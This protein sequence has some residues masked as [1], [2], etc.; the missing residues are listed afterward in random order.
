MSTGCSR[1]CRPHRDSSAPTTRGRRGG[2]GRSGAVIERHPGRPC[3][4]VG[5]CYVRNC[6]RC[7]HWRNPEPRLRPPARRGSSCRAWLRPPFARSARGS[8]LRRRS[9]SRHAATVSLRRSLPA[10]EASCRRPGARTSLE[11]CPAVRRRCGR[12]PEVQV[13]QP[14]LSLVSLRWHENRRT[15]WPCWNMPGRK[16]SVVL[17]AVFKCAPNATPRWR[18]NTQTLKLAPNM[19]F[20]ALAAE[21]RCAAIRRAARA[22]VPPR[23]GVWHYGKPVPCHR[24]Q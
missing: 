7:P 18:I 14:S 15:P 4:S 1:G 11:R 9:K 20:E 10:G 21:F 12:R 13:R 16:S 5:R 3:A 23:S 24:P 6:Q 22:S 19:R 2:P 17:L 8:R